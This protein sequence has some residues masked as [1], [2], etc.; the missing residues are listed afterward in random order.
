MKQRN[1]RL[2]PGAAS[3]ILIVVVLCMS[4]LGMLTL[5]SARSDDT[6][7]RRAAEVVTAVGELNTKAEASMAALDKLLVEA[8]KDASGDEEY[9]EKIE[10]ALP[11]GMKLDGQSVRW[12]EDDGSRGLICRAEIA[13]LGS[14]PRAAFTEHRLWADTQT[15]GFMAELEAI[16][17]RAAEAVTDEKYAELLD[18]VRATLPEDQQSDDKAVMSA[19]YELIIRGNLPEDM[20]LEGN[21]VTWQ[22]ETGTNI[23]DCRAEIAPLGIFPRATLTA[24]SL[25]E[26]SEEEWN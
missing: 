21:V 18:Q 24:Y 25:A 15:D 8:A 16:L 9:L 5:M 12:I 20:T 6:L 19:A 4:V 2:G 17:D 3:L 22:A 11:E 1:I 7:S 13:P 26:E 23:I 14:F 10:S